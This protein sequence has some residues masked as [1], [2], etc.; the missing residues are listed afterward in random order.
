M[1]VAFKNNFRFQFNGASRC[2][3]LASRTL[4]YVP[5]MENSLQFKITQMQLNVSEPTR[6]QSNVDVSVLLLAGRDSASVLD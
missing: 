1:K 2:V 4:I 5:R 3:A 6:D